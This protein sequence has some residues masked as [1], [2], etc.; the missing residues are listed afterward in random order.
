[1]T[2]K[3]KQNGRKKI[4]LILPK[5]QY[6]NYYGQTEL[7][8]MMGKKKFMLSLAMPMIAALTP[9]EYEVRIIDEDIEKLPKELPDI[10]G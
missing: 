3:K 4:Y 10:A 5:Q 9:P 1:M 2:S 6:V 7:C 8:K